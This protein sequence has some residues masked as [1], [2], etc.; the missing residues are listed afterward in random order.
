[1]TQQRQ[2]LPEEILKQSVYRTNYWHVILPERPV[3][4][5]HLLL[6]A[7]RKEAD[8]FTSLTNDELIELRDTIKYLVTTLNDNGDTL[9]GYN[10]FSNNGAYSIGQHLDRFHQHIFM[11]NDNEIESPY[12]VMAEGRRWASADSDEWASRRDELRLIFN[13]PANK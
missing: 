10:V 8:I 4:P 7:N 2:I 5:Y 1:M 12:V 9:L 11:R 13:P 3:N 6:V